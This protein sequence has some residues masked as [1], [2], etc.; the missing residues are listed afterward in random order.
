M[1]HYVPFSHQAHAELLERISIAP[2]IRIAAYTLIARAH[3][4]I[5][6]YSI[7][8]HKGNECAQKIVAPTCTPFMLSAIMRI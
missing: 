8:V 7:R 6:S 5:R 2:T 4:I 1:P 3:I